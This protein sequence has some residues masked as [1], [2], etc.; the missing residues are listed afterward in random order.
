MIFQVLLI[1]YF[2]PSGRMYFKNNSYGH[3]LNFILHEKA[4]QGF[5]NSW[6]YPC[7]VKSALSRTHHL[8]N[9]KLNSKTKVHYSIRWADLDP[10]EHRYLI[11]G[12]FK[13]GLELYD[14]DK[15]WMTNKF[16]HIGSIKQNHP[17]MHPEQIT[18]VQWYP[19]DAG[20]V[21][22]SSYS[23]RKLKIWDPNLLT[24]ADEFHLPSTVTHHHMS[25]VASG[26]SLIATALHSGEVV[27]C[28][29]RTGS[30]SHSLRSKKRS[31]KP[32]SFVQWSNHDQNILASGGDDNQVRIWDVRFA[33]ACTK[34]LNETNSD[35]GCIC[36]LSFSYDGLWLVSLSSQHKNSV[37][38]WDTKTFKRSKVNI[39]LATDYSSQPYRIDITRNLYP[40]CLYIPSCNSIRAYNLFNGSLVNTI[41]CH[42]RG[43]KGVIY[44][45]LS[46]DLYAFG[47]KKNFLFF[48]PKT[49]TPGRTLSEENNEKEAKRKKTND[50][51]DQCQPLI[52]EKLNNID[53][54]DRWSSDKRCW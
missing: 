7:V 20:L 50:I 48:S 27:L 49:L 21:L 11:M 45:P 4:K 35:F 33:K 30:A 17:C 3:K 52:A 1:I 22:S 32:A 53:Y 46:S 31:F 29:L 40:D 44:N 13:A 8:T 12:R 6:E 43:V 34:I 41:K 51:D 19:Y 25:S 42:D 23:D 28:D 47:G 10:V 9:L 54:S 14:T 5:I 2:L 15:S 38:L 18:C 26:H 39:K 36:A 16:N 37:S 24:L